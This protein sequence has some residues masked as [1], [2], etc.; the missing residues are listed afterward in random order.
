VGGAWQQRSWFPLVVENP[1][2]D[3]YWEIGK[4]LLQRV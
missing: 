2:T 1:P 4:P 3:L